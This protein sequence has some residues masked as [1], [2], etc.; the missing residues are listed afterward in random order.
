MKSNPHTGASVVIV[1]QSRNRIRLALNWCSHYNSLKS[2][3]YLTDLSLLIERPA[4]R[5]IEYDEICKTSQASFIF[6]YTEFKERNNIFS[7]SVLIFI[8]ICGW[9][10]LE[11]CIRWKR[12]KKYRIFHALP[13]TYP[14]PSPMDVYKFVIKRC[15]F[16]IHDVFRTLIHV[17]SYS[18]L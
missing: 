7:I 17:Y 14:N 3:T 8:L 11:I 4:I 5:H 10:P 1:I 6:E 16:D 18:S 9:K 13:P 15:L 2:Q 12:V